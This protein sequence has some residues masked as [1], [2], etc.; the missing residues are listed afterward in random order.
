M[1]DVENKFNSSIC[2]AWVDDVEL[3]LLLIKKKSK[4][5]DVKK[6][7][8]KSLFDDILEQK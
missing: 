2:D 1:K 5:A 6:S 3:A 8:V 7:E 4:Q